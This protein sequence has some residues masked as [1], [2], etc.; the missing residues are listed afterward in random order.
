MKGEALINVFKRHVTDEPDDD[1]I[2]DLINIV[3]D[4]VEGARKWRMLLKEYATQTFGASDDYT[5]EKDLPSDFLI[6][7]KLKLGIEANDDYTE[8]PPCAFEDRRQ[9]NAKKRYC[10][11]YANSKLYVCGS[12]SLTYTIYLYYIYETD[13][14]TATTSPVWPVKFQRIIPLLAAEIWK[15]GIDADVFNLQQA[16]ALSKPGNI[17]FKAMVQWDANLWQ[18]AM[19]NRT[20]IHGSG[21]GAEFDGLVPDQDNLLG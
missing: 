6:D 15:S 3:K 7:V 21:L 4:L 17:L 13:P 11:D 16:L 18:K 1:T 2:L 20:P 10:I 5:T 12:V 9:F 19:N 14:I 8:Y